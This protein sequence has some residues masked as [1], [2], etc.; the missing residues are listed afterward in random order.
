M[1]NGSRTNFCYL[2]NDVICIIEDGRSGN[3]F[4]PCH[5]FTQ[6]SPICTICSIHV[7]KF[8]TCHH[9]LENLLPDLVYFRTF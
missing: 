8:S 9:P 2:S 3:Q 1:S 6:L 4:S 5:H 7:G